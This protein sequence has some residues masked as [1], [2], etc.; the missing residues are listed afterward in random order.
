ME[1]KNPQNTI[2]GAVSDIATHTQYHFAET[3]FGHTIVKRLFFRCVDFA[4]V[5]KSC[6]ETMNTVD[7]NSL[8]Y[9]EG[10]NTVSY[11]GIW[12]LTHALLSLKAILEVVTSVPY[13]APGSWFIVIRLHRVAILRIG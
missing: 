3:S 1:H 13:E 2:H 5:S 10:Y 4:R 8:Y 9:A 12:K 6:Y 7:V 11:H